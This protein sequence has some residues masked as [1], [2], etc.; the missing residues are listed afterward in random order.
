MELVNKEIE[1]LE[2]GSTTLYSCSKL[3]DLYTIRHYMGTTP[4]QTEKNKEV[5]SAYD[6]Y[7][8]KKKMYNEGNL[9]K[10]ELVKTMEAVSTEIKEMIH[11]LFEMAELPE[12]KDIMVQTVATLKTLY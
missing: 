9:S 2:N 5:V 1:E 10:D 12:E 4:T 11:T 7:F 6:D 8:C 3:A